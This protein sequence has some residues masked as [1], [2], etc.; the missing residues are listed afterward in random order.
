MMTRISDFTNVHTMI[1]FFVRMFLFV[2]LKLFS[3]FQE[4]TGFLRDSFHIQTEQSRIRELKDTY[5]G[6][7]CFVIC[8]GPSLNIDDLELIKDEY[9]FAMNSISL[10]FDKTDFRPSFYG[11]IDEG[12]FEKMKD[13]IM[14]Y[15]SPNT[16]VFISGRLR[17]YLDSGLP[18]YWY[19]VSCNVAYHTYDR[20][21]RNKFWCKFSDNAVRGTYDMYSVTHFLIQIAAYMGFSEVYLVGADCNF[22]KGGKIHFIEHGIPDTTIDTARERNICGYEE[23]RRY[24]QTHDLKVYNATRGGMLETFN[25]VNLDTLIS[26]R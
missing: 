9:T 10:L 5:K 22:P 7:R 17:K 16:K 8:T 26:L 4:I 11:C 3:L 25:R 24:T 2:V 20:W 19:N 13:S 6:K 21:F 18:S 12:V 23:I 1:G 14:K 15:D